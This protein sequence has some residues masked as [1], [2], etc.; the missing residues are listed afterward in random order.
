LLGIV[1]VVLVITILVQAWQISALKVISG[2]AVSSGESYEE[3]M[4]RMH[5]DQVK[6]PSTNSKSTPS[7]GGMVGGC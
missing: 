2:N 3:M 1:L 5:P 4:A 7:S 6:T